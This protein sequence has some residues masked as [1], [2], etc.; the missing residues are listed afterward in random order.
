MKQN[1]VLVIA[2]AALLLVGCQTT[3]DQFTQSQTLLNRTIAGEPPGNYFVG[4]RF[5]R[6]NFFFW[7]YI[8]QP[9]EPWSS[10]K[11]VM[12]N[13]QKMLAPDRQA[14]K[15]GF[16]SNYEYRLQG[17]FSGQT[18]YEPASN[19]FYPEFVLTSYKLISNHPPQIF[20]DPKAMDPDRL[21]IDKPQ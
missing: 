3:E 17:Y 10:S 12:M 4:R 16:D 5:Y 9:R 13:E 11:L 2:A 19:S 6:K 18:V 20:R 14:N 7:G 8:R 1:V 15:A 21:Y